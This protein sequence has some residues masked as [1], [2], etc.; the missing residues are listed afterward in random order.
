[1]SRL[2][3]ARAEAA[4]FLLP[5]Q[6]LVFLLQSAQNLL[7]PNT[8]PLAAD[9]LQLLLQL[10]LSPGLPTAAAGILP[11]GS[12]L[13]TVQHPTLSMLPEPQSAPAG[14]G[15]SPVVV[16]CLGLGF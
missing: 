1:M 3:P 14:G 6:P 16:R 8:D 15:P 10:S 7:F 13:D 4:A 2:A 11:A 12:G 9:M 5:A